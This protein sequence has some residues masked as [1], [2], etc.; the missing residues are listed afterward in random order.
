[1]DITAFSK[2]FET[3]IHVITCHSIITTTYFIMEQTVFSKT[4]GTIIN[5]RF[6]H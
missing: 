2:T 6:Q 1:M 4:S 5:E 3:M